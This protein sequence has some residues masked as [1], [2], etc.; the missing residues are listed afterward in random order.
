MINAVADLLKA[1]YY[2]AR[3]QKMYDNMM[4]CLETL[5]EFVQGPCMEN[6][7]AVSESKFFHIASDIFTAKKQKHNNAAVGGGADDNYNHNN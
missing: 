1:Y 4:Q 6:Q 7:N 2:E 3:T 5:T